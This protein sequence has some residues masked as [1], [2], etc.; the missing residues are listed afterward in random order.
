MCFL[1]SKRKNRS[2]SS[3][4][5]SPLGAGGSGRAAVSGG[6]LEARA[7]SQ[8]HAAPGCALALSQP[9]AL[10]A[11]TPGCPALLKVTRASRK[12]ASEAPHGTPAPVQTEGVQT[13]RVSGVHICAWWRAQLCLLTWG[14]AGAA[15]VPHPACFLPGAPRAAL[16]VPAVCG[17]VVDSCRP[18]ASGLS[19]GCLG[20]TAEDVRG[21]RERSGPGVCS[22]AVAC[23]SG[24]EGSLCSR[25]A[26]VTAF[27]PFL[28]RWAFA[29]LWG[30][31]S[32]V[33]G[34][35]L[36]PLCLCK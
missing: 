13:T 5:S 23:A 3:P 8:R 24:P 15:G 19:A 16:L 2:V 10:K 6:G 11:D 29:S 21:R 17:P 18:A 34:G 36:S 9:S 27:L 12:V 4:N 1:V 28:H 26:P 35:P 20:L 22:A 32:P 31:S 25:W 30:L 14:A 33:V 7:S